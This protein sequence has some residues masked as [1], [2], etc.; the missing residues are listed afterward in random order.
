MTNY[1]VSVDLSDVLA[2]H[3]AAVQAMFPALS[4][5]VRMTAEHGANLWRDAI[6]KAKL[7]QGEKEEYAGTVQWTMVSA[8]EAEIWSDYKHAGEI[9][10]GRPAR[11]MKAVLQTSRKTRLATKGKHAGQ[12]Y[13]IIPFRHNT[14]GYTAHARPMPKGIYAQAKALTASTVLPPGT[15]KFPYR[16]SA[17]GNI[18]AQHSYQWGGKLPKG[19]VPKMKEHHV[20]DIYDSMVRMNTSAGKGK[21]SAYLTFRTMGEWSHHWIVP[22]K[23]GLYIVKGVAVELQPLLGEAVGMAIKMGGP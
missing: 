23:P 13:L 21:S 18:V 6:F 10:T 20:T 5:A 3:E 17:S 15:K 7:W 12:K 8:Y 16:V 11:D 2:Q 4:Q 19:L 1:R 9:E 22:A 14:P